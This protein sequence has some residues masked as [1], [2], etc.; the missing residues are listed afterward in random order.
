VIVS[1]IGRGGMGIVYRAHD[2]KLG[3]TVALKRPKPEVMALPDFGRRFLREARTAS[4]LLHPNIT[5][6]FAAYEMEG[7][8]WL[9]MEFVEG[10]S[11]RARLAGGE[12]LPVNEVVEH[13]EGLADALR[14]AHEQGILHSDVNPNN[15]LIGRDGR[16][17]LTDFGLARA[18]NAPGAPPAFAAGEVPTWSVP[19]AAGTRG[20]MSPEHLRG[21]PLDPRS[22]I[23]CLGLVLY[24]MCVGA[25]AFAGKN[26][27]EWIGAALDGE[28][29]RLTRLGPEVPP[30]LARVIAKATAS[31]PGRRYQSAG[32]MAA[33]LR[34]LRRFR[35]SGVEIAVAAAA[36]ARK[37]TTYGVL[38][39]ALVAAAAGSVALLSSRTAHPPVLRS[40]PL[41]SGPGLEEQPAISPDGRLVAYTSNES[42]NDDIWLADLRTGECRRLTSDQG[43]ER[44]PAWFPDGS[45]VAY[46][47]KRAEDSSIWRFPVGGGR[48]VR[49]LAVGEGPDVSPD[50][51]RLAFTRRDASAYLRIVV[52]SLAD[53]S[54]QTVLTDSGDGVEDHRHPKWSPDGTMIAYADMRHIW[55]VPAAGGRAAQLTRDPAGNREPAWSADGRFVYFSSVREGPQSLWRIPAAGGAP[56]RLTQGTG[57]E[58]QPSVSRAGQRL[59]Y[60]TRREEYD[61]EVRDLR[62]RRT[63]RISSSAYDGMP[64]VSPDGRCVAFMSNRL[65]SY[66]LWMQRFEPGGPDGPARRLTSL[67]GNVAMPVFT[68]DGRWIAFHRTVGTA[69]DIW[70]VP[71]DGGA[72]RQLTDHPDRE[73]HP[74][75]SPDS[76][77]AAFVSNRSGREQLWICGF[78]GDR[79][80]GEPRQLTTGEGASFGPDWSPDGD[81][82]VFVSAT[83]DDTE[84]WVAHADGGSPPRQVSFGARVAWVRWGAARRTILAA[85]QW[86]GGDLELRRLDLGTGASEALDPP[87]AFGGAGAQDDF[88]VSADGGVLAF[89][90]TTAVG[91]IWLTEET[92]G[93]R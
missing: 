23:Y 44:D 30:E 5:T 43:D 49:L 67:P 71:A 81:Q 68:P 86:A 60:A 83:G 38:A 9:V 11:L 63:W 73:V 52:T 1:E 28:T 80:T 87:V 82:I 93:S 51:S 32:E 77:R 72:A 41:T 62:A 42:G 78:A 33:D 26:T 50:G 88:A 46:T 76:T 40:R 20:Y 6:V 61:V 90:V 10:V 91:D 92:N 17:R 25:P 57:P 66:D 54:R 18:R 31:K 59:A 53:V 56:E 34:A 24:E 55:L 13:G 4:K 48:P 12:P 74:A 21:Q 84:A 37:R 47:L 14:A 89:T 70:M 79:M 15:I 3:R 29:E 8:P 69:K 64:A 16:A 65:G 35:E 45:A 2:V 22:D 58:S 27:V 85:G 7:V 75:F 19:E 39:A 36:H